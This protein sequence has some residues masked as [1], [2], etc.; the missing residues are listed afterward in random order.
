MT[1]TGWRKSSYSNGA[2]MCAEVG[3]WRTASF[4]YNG[5]SCVEAGN[6]RSSS[7][8]AAGECLEAASCDHGV[9]VRDT[10]LAPFSPVLKF[11]GEK[12]TRFLASLRA[13]A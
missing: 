8:C 5:S 9:A 12:W 3:S 2:D 1:I 4:S 10:T 7:R 13:D 11:S 6:W